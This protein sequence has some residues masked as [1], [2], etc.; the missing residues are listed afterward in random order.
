MILQE[1]GWNWIVQCY[2]NKPHSER[3]ILHVITYVESRYKFTHVGTVLKKVSEDK[4]EGNEN[5]S[6][7]V[8]T[9]NSYTYHMSFWR[10]NTHTRKTKKTFNNLFYIGYVLKQYFGLLGYHILKLTLLAYNLCLLKINMFHIIL[11][12]SNLVWRECTGCEH[13]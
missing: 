12:L 1:N 6:H 10:F 8:V 5:Y 7:C 4:R 13:Q 9:K 3:Q 2:F 11:I